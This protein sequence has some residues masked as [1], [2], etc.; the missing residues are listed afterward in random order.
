VWPALVA[1]EDLERFRSATG[2]VAARIA[3]LL[4]PKAQAWWEATLGADDPDAQAH[5]DGAVERL[6]A[7]AGRGSDRVPVTQAR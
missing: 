5:D 2:R 6:S 7:G 3:C 4:G 1:S